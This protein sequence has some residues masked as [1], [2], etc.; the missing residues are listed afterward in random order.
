MV[1]KSMLRL[2]PI[3]AP[4]AILMISTGIVCGQ[5]TEALQLQPREPYSLNLPKIAVSVDNVTNEFNG[6][7]INF[8]GTDDQV[9]IG[10]YDDYYIKNTL[11]GSEKT[12]Y[13]EETEKAGFISK[14]EA[15]YISKV[16]KEFIIALEQFDGLLQKGN[17]G[18]CRYLD[19]FFPRF[20]T[21]YFYLICAARCSE[22][23]LPRGARIPEECFDV[24]LNSPKTDARINMW[25]ASPE[26]VIKLRIA[27]KELAQ[28]LRIWQKDIDKAKENDDVASSKEME[29]SLIILDRVYFNLKPPI[30]VVLKRPRN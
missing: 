7:R 15:K 26:Y 20:L 21:G 23:A 13:R 8:A 29:E 12:L 10:T 17:W 2:S 11:R 1:L 28:Q 14:F 4:A 6:V 19:C 9:F 30:P 18:R 3:A 27:S 5:D 22:N 24:S 16:N 25:R